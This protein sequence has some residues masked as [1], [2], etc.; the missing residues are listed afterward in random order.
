MVSNAY[1]NT[2][3]PDQ[4]TS[5]D[6][7]SITYHK[8]GN[9]ESY[10][11]WD[12]IWKAGRQLATMSN[13]SINISYT[14]DDMGIRTSKTVKGVKI[15]YTSINGRITSQTTDTNTVYFLYDKYEQLVGFNLIGPEYVY[16]LNGQGD[17]TGIL[18]SNGNRLINYSYDAW[19]KCT[20]V[21]DS[22]SNK[23]G[24]L[25]PLRYRGYYLD[26][27]T[28]LFYVGSRYYDSGIGRWINADDPSVLEFGAYHI[29]GANLFAFCGNNPIMGRDTNGY[30]NGWWGKKRNNGYVFG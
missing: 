10:L 30:W 5:Y 22:S 7:Q 21:S 24:S 3:F 6:G 1:E 2:D 16:T 12:M 26:S 17:I 23:I 28:G 19:G 15:T 29:L 8:L 27:E 4:T 13:G 9:P 11:G 25:N 14:Y 20:I 18:D